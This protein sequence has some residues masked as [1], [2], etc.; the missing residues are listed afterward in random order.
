M[1]VPTKGIH[2]PGEM[3]TGNTTFF[4]A[5]TLVDITDSG[6]SD[7]KNS[8]VTFRQAQ[9]LNSLIQALSLRTQLVLSSVDVKLSQDLSDYDFGSDFT[10]SH[11]VWIYKFASE[12]DDIFRKGDDPLFF[13]RDDV[14][15]VPTY[16]GLDETASVSESFDCNDSN[17]KNMYFSFSESL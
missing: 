13:A 8:S 2:R 12:T 9:N 5:Y 7:P 1:S 10:G 3:L 11:T 14:H 16:I 17:S 15:G 4:I 6:N